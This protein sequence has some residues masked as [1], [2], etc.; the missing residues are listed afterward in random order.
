MDSEVFLLFLTVLPPL[1]ADLEKGRKELGRGKK[2]KELFIIG[3][4]K[5]WNWMV[6]LHS[7]F[8]DLMAVGKENTGSVH[9]K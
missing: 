9:Q 8:L 4:V 5:N 6:L 1:E 7:E 2:G 3:H